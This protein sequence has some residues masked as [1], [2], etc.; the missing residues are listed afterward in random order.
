[1]ETQVPATTLQEPEQVTGGEV[2]PIT[3][4]VLLPFSSRQTSRSVLQQASPHPTNRVFGVV[5]SG[6]I[7]CPSFQ[8]ALRY[9]LQTVEHPSSNGGNPMK[10]VLRTA[11]VASLIRSVGVLGPWK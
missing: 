11:M 4:V 8:Q 10:F 6:T 1:M 5:I 2:W 9:S 7:P 3:L